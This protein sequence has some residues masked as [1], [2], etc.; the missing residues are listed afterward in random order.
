MKLT[1]F[2]ATGGTGGHVVRQA[3]DAGH[4]VTAVVRD[5]AKLAIEHADLRV[6]TPHVTNPSAL[7]EALEGQDAVIS[8]LGANGRKGVGIASAATRSI[9]TAMDD[10]GVRRFAAISAVPVGELP[11]GEPF[12]SRAIMIPLLRAILREVYADLAVMEKELRGS[13]AEWRIARPPYL[14][15]GPLTGK[16][17]TTIGGT[18][19][20]GTSI[21]RADLAHAMLAMVDNPATARQVVGVAY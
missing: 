2:G 5:P 1:V 19:P 13:D 10:C 21:S 9:L 4:Q 12:F 20:R 16:Y 17:R 18:V 6:L 7:H 14:T 11:D 3:L 8:A 15:K